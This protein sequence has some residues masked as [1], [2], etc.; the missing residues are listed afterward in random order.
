MKPKFTFLVIIAI[1]Y[2]LQL[3]NAQNS[4]TPDGG[5]EFIFN[6]SQRPCSTDEQRT[7][8]LTDIKNGIQELSLENQDN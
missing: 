2:N 7:Q 1:F 8:M 3:V 4:P 5:R 6:E